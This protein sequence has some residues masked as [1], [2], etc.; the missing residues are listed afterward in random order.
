MDLRYTLR[1]LVKAPGFTAVAVLVMALGIGANTA[2]FSVVNA[3]LLRPLGYR[4]ADRIVTLYTSWK[5]TGPSSTVSA[6]DFHDWHDQAT[7]FDAMAYYQYNQSVITVGA[8]AEYGRTSAVTPEFFRVF[9]EDVSA[10]RLFTNEETKAGGVVVISDSFARAHFGDSAAAL[11]KIVRIQD[12]SATVV[13]VLPPRFHFPEQAD[14]WYPANTFFG[15]SSSRSGHNYLVVGRLKP[16]VTVEQAQAEMASIASGLE[17]LYP[18]SN[19][20]KSVKVDR[21]SDT[22]V[23]QVRLTLYLMLGSVGLVLLIACANVANLLLARATSRTREIAIRAAVGASRMRIIRQLIVESV[24]LA[25]AGGIG[26]VLLAVWGT[27]AF[28]ALAP[29]NV[30]RLGDSGLDAGVLAFT[31]AISLA[32]SLVFGLAPAISA[33]R[34]DLN[35]ALKQGAT[36]SVMGGASGRL[37]KSLVIAEVALSV[38]LLTGAGLLIKS[39]AA[40]HDVALGFRPENVLVM[41]S[42]VAGSDLESSKA[43]T[44]VVKGMLEEVAAVPGVLVSGATMA[45][46]GTVRSNGGYWIDHLPPLNELGVSA[47]QAVFSVIAP[48]TF[49]TLGIP[50]KTGRD[51]DRSDIYDTQFTAIINESL[52]RASFPGQDPIGRVIFCGLDAPNPMRIVAVVGDIRQYGPARPPRPEIFMPYQQHPFAGRALNILARTASDPT[53]LSETLRRKIR[54]RAPDVPVRF[55]TMEASLAQNVA[56]PRFRTTLL[57][58][59]AALAV[60]LAMAGVYG[61]M[62]YTVGQRSNEIGLRMALGATSV[63]IA[64]MVL[65]HGAVLAAIGVAAGL[66]GAAAATRLLTNLLFDVKPFDPLTY[67]AVA[68]LMVV[69]AMGASYLPA[70]RAAKLDPLAALRQE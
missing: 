50:I 13:G 41:T 11:G 70:R 60:A 25:I 36:R 1:T 17:K 34:V 62:A 57:G 35:E 33:S 26:G 54:E 47:P 52:A 46:P 29:A 63:D 27:S 68:A 24:I 15:E 55:T 23:S 56:A 7:S 32:A 39:F 19:R 6:P 20:E 61:V 21:L 10:G 66:A 3:V 4:D 28:V 16:G 8:N 42:S 53:Q 65:K 40:L 18:N 30:P 44:Q 51:F 49:A 9:Q 64:A 38:V 45:V 22:M 59:F 43:A 37:R 12:K 2:M 69:V 48:G 31:F 14:L 67:V 58:I 5:R